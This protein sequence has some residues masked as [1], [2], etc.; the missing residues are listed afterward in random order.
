MLPTDAST[1]QGR[2]WPIGAIPRRAH[3]SARAARRPVPFIPWFS[4]LWDARSRRLG[5]LDRH[6]RRDIGLDAIDV[7]HIDASAPP[8]T[9]VLASIAFRGG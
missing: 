4:L 5:D 1:I 7:G 3:R 9:V 8:M 6:L 2:W